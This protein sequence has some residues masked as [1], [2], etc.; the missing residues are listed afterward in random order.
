[1]SDTKEPNPQNEV[2]DTVSPIEEIHDKGH[3]QQGNKQQ[4]YTWEPSEEMLQFFTRIHKDNTLSQEEQ[5]I[6]QSLMDTRSLLL[7]GLSYANDIR[8]D[9]TIK[10]ISPSYNPPAEYEEVCG[11]TKLNELITQENEKNKMSKS[12]FESSKTPMKYLKSQGIRII[13]YLD[14]LLI[15]ADSEKEAI[16]HQDLTLNYLQLLGFTINN[17]KSS[18][19]PTNALEYL[20]TIRECQSIFKKQEI[21]IRKLVSIIGKLIFITNAVFLAHLRS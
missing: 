16:I 4:G 13:A 17:K 19:V 5:A 21:H 15:I 12:F 18:L 14:D 8:R 11:P 2:Q 6:E 20:D 1:M 10:C 3:E 9:Q 7:N